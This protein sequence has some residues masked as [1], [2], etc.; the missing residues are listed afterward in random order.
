MA[1]D[2]KNISPDKLNLLVTIVPHDKELFYLDYLQ[3]LGANLQLSLKGHGTAG[4]EYLELIGL[5]NNDKSVLFSVIRAERTERI[6]TGLEDKFAAIRDGKGI[7]CAIP[8]SS[9]IGKLSFGF[10]SGDSRMVK[11]EG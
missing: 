2:L 11:G 10:L 6:L 5:D 3:T 4:K 1:K 9:V 8:L 7:A